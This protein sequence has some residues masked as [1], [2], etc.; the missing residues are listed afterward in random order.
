MGLARPKITIPDHAFGELLEL[1][2]SFSWNLDDTPGGKDD[3]INPAVLG[4]I[5][6]KYINQKEFGAF[7]T[8]TEITETPDALYALGT[9]QL[10]KKQYKD[11][12]TRLERYVVIQVGEGDGLIQ[13]A[14]AYEGAGDPA[15]AL[16]TYETART[17]LADDP[18]VNAA[19]ARLK[20]Q[21]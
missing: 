18:E 9:L 17:Y 20:G 12:I 8:R 16:K 15:A 13:L 11:A 3:E 10:Q 4:Y 7:Y 2:Q 1:F 5:F 21:Q 14:K 19:I 6:E